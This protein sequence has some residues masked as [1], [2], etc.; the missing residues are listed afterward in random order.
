MEAADS[1]AAVE[2]AEEAR[3]SIAIA[4][5]SSVAARGMPTTTTT[6]ITLLQNAAAVFE[7]PS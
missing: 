5:S 4:H 2:A 1:G 6:I 7:S 3:H